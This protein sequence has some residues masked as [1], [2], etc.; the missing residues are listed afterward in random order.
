MNKVKPKTKKEKREESEAQVRLLIA[1]I[2]LACPYL[3][4][5]TIEEKLMEKAGYCWKPLTQL[6]P[7]RV[8][9]HSHPYR[10]R[11]VNPDRKFI[12]NGGKIL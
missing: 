12:A 4:D 8:S 10:K 7:K 9:K 2:R 5:R 3:S 6:I 1:R 11:F